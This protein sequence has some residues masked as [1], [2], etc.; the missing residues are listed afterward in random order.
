MGRSQLVPATTNDSPTGLQFHAHQL[1]RSGQPPRRAP[2]RQCHGDEWQAVCT[3]I[4]SAA[5]RVD[6]AADLV[7]RRLSPHILIEPVIHAQ[8]AIPG[9]I[10]LTVKV[11]SLFT[12]EI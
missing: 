5:A 9:S 12:R 2:Q 6:A 7:A 4:P 11:R 8:I 1:R 3:T 10:H